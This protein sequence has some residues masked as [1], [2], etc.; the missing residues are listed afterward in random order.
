[1]A[2]AHV[3]WTRAALAL[4]LLG[5]LDGEEKSYGYALL[6]RLADAG[7]EGVKAATLY[8][9]LA[10]LEEESAVEIE[11]GAGE[12]GPGRKYYRITE[13][14][15]ARLR[16]DQAAWG[17]FTRTVASLL[18]KGKGDDSG[19]HTRDAHDAGG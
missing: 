13:E 14:G 9:A 4:C 3:A 6:G 17:D 2:D 1:M 12:G 10:R 15:R 8:P 5:I 11:W 18:G 16:R 19:E 7:L